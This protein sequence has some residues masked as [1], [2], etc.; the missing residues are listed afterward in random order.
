MTD[1]DFK[2]VHDNDSLRPFE[3]GFGGAIVYGNDE[4]D[5]AIGFVI[6]LRDRNASLYHFK[7]N[8]YDLYSFGQTGKNIWEGGIEKNDIIEAKIALD[9]SKILI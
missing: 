1:Y 5:I 8:G 9:N 4:K 3:K 7:L 6:D 2:I